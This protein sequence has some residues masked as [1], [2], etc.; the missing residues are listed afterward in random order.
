MCF[1]AISLMFFSPSNTLV[2][3]TL[4]P[5]VLLPIPRVAFSLVYFPPAPCC[6]LSYLFAS[7]SLPLFVSFLAPSVLLLPSCPLCWFPCA[8]LMLLLPTLGTQMLG[9]R[10]YKMT[11]AATY[12]FFLFNS[13]AAQYAWLKQLA[14]P[15]GSK[16]ATYWLCQSL[17]N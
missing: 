7:T 6:A 5:R 9:V 12:Y 16:G 14:K 1:P 3:L 15:I 17:F 10:T 13:H 11:Q 4:C 2:L 8:P